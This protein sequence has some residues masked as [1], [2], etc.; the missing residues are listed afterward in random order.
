MLAQI[1]GFRNNEGDT[2][3]ESIS[4]TNSGGG[5]PREFKNARGACVRSFTS[6]Q[7]QRGSHRQEL[8]KLFHGIHPIENRLWEK[9]YRTVLDHWLRRKDEVRD[10][11]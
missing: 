1:D 2:P 5:T 9:F 10:A 7:N 6:L 3:N 11:L 8:A 4:C